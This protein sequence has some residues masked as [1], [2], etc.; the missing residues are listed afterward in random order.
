M[1]VGKSLN[2]SGILFL[3]KCHNQ[4]SLVVQWLRICLP[5]QQTWVWSLVWEDSTYHGTTQPVCYNYWAY[6]LEMPWPPFMALRKL[7]R[8]TPQFFPFTYVQE[9]DFLG[10]TDH[11]LWVW[12]LDYQWLWVWLHR[13]RISRNYNTV[14]LKS[15][16]F[17]NWRCQESYF[18][19]LS[20]HFFILKIQSK[21]FF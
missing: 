18:T 3:Q 15:W 4:T 16:V 2:I 13:R 11:A 12:V 10:D 19:T 17:G 21:T 5:M 8:L 20:F 9:C 14:K 1:T 7:F 6:T